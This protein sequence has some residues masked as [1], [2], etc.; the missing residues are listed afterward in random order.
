MHLQLPG[1]SARKRMMTYPLAGTMTVSL[2]G[3]LTRLT[4]GMGPLI[5]DGS[6]HVALVHSLFKQRMSGL[7]A[8]E[9]PVKGSKGG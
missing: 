4:P 5:Q 7:N 3:G 8:V 6:A 1:L 9:F 2:I